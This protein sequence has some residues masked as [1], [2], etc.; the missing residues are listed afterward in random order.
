MPPPVDHRFLG[1]FSRPYPTCDLASLAAATIRRTNETHH[2]RS[3]HL[4]DAHDLRPMS[5][6]VPTSAGIT[7]AAILRPA[8]SLAT[9]NTYFASN[10]V[11]GEGR[12]KSR[13]NR[14]HFVTV[15]NASS[16]DLIMRVIHAGRC[17]VCGEFFE[18]RLSRYCSDQCRVRVWQADRRKHQKPD[19]HRCDYC[20][21]SLGEAARPQ[22]RYCSAACR[23][24]AYRERR[25]T[26]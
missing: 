22:A 17:P 24:A 25:G 4:A 2:L 21:G 7:P 26:A 6:S 13:A 1:T 20:V 11:A 5:P 16:G 23:Q 10:R 12:G 8:A 9:Q 19:L 15:S 18:D 3:S 14:L